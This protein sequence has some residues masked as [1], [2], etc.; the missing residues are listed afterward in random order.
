M[1]VRWETFE[2]EGNADKVSISF[3]SDNEQRYIIIMYD[4]VEKDVIIS[5]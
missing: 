2:R 5:L 4:T 1:Y 3:L